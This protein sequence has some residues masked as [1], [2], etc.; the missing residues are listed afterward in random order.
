VT[1]YGSESR[2]RAARQRIPH[3]LEPDA[4]GR[5]HVVLQFH[6]RGP[7]GRATVN[8]DMREE[9]GGWRY[10]YLYLDV[11]APV[12]QRVVIARPGQEDG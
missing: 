2:N 12:P 1:A 6:L 11:E 9:G 8:A 10:R 7:A 3:R 5:E 4:L